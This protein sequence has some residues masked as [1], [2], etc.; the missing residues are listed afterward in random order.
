MNGVF[1]RSVT[2]KTQSGDVL[3]IA[4]LV[5]SLFLASGM[6]IARVNILEY[7][8]STEIAYSNV[9]Y[10][11][12]EIAMEVALNQIYKPV[13]TGVSQTFQT[14]LQNANSGSTFGCAG[15]L[16]QFPAGASGGTAYFKIAIYK[17]SN[18]NQFTD[19]AND[20]FAVN[21]PANDLQKN[22]GLVKTWGYY[23]GT[24][25]SVESKILDTTP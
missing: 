3:I 20:K 2:H 16:I 18:G 4:L 22:I 12:A 1:Q 19:C 10:Q 23:K 13:N 24:V 11:Q 9:A 8:A 7:K 6:T 14:Y 25:R 15:G 17:R 5:T 21:P